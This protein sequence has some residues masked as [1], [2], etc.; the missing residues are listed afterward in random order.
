MVYKGLPVMEK[1][2]NYMIA[3]DRP[4]H[5][6]NLNLRQVA[7]TQMLELR[8]EQPG[9]LSLPIFMDLPGKCGEILGTMVDE[10]VSKIWI[11]SFGFL[12]AGVVSF[13][14]FL[15]VFYSLSPAFPDA[16]VHFMKAQYPG[17]ELGHAVMANFAPVNYYNAERG[18]A[19]NVV[20]NASPR[21]DNLRRMLGALR[22]AGT[23]VFILSTSW[24]P[25]TAEQVSS[26]LSLYYRIALG[27]H[28]STVRIA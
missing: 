19:G 16:M 26:T 1:Y 4:G 6:T 14:T 27:A 7:M 28:L 3:V 24:W 20:A 15:M 8:A 12:K 23:K 22:K 2:L 17:D 5:G 9:S 25:V 10:S 13:T 18:G 11:G 21:V